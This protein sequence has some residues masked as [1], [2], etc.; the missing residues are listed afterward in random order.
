MSEYIVYKHT[1]PNGKCY[2]GLTCQTIE[3]RARGG[4][5]YKE[6]T[7][8]YNAILK[9]GWDNLRHEVLESGLTYDEACVREC[10]YINKFHSLTTEWGYNLVTGGRVSRSMPEESK[11]KISQTLTGRKGTPLS[12]EARMKI[13]AAQKGRKHPPRSDE[14]RKKISDALKGR[15]FTPK[16][17][18]NI[19]KAKSGAATSGKNNS[20]PK[21]VLCVETGTVF[22]TIKEAGEFIGGSSKNIISCCRGRLKTSGG[23]HWRYFDGRCDE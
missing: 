15:T 10:F 7:A 1:A 9:Y 13:G 11:R 20:H 23:Y 3:R 12:P 16:H 18:A 22:A 21:A 17:R 2:I 5:G 4:R 6:C 19:S 14:Y 8:F